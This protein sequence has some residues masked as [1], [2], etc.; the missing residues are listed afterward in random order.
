MEDEKE[1]TNVDTSKNTDD[2]DHFIAKEREEL[3]L[4]LELHKKKVIKIILACIST[5][6]ILAAIFV[7]LSAGISITNL[8]SIY[9]DTIDCTVSIILRLI[10]LYLLTII[11]IK[12]GN[13]KLYENDSKYIDIKARLMQF[14]L[15]VWKYIF[16]HSKSKIHNANNENTLNNKTNSTTKLYST[17][18]LDELINKYNRIDPVDLA[19]FWKNTIWLILFAFISIF[20]A[21]IGIKTVFFVTSNYYLHFL[22]GFTIFLCHFEMYWIQKY[23]DDCTEPDNKF[24]DANIHSHPMFVRAVPGNWCDLCWQRIDKMCYRCNNCD[25]DVCAKCWKKEKKAKKLSEKKN[26][27]KYSGDVTVYEY[28]KRLFELY[29]NHWIVLAI[30]LIIVFLTSLISVRLPASRGELFDYIFEINLDNFYEGLK[31][32]IILTVIQGLL[33]AVHNILTQRVE[34]QIMNEVQQSLYERI[35]KQ[36]MSYFDNSTA[37]VLV[38]R[39]EYGLNDA[40]SPFLSLTNSTITNTISLIGSLYFC[41]QYSFRLLLLAFSTLGPMTYLSVLFQKWHRSSMRAVWYF[42]SDLYRFASESFTN[43]RTIRSYSKEPSMKKHYNN[44]RN[45]LHNRKMK[46]ALMNALNNTIRSWF[47]LASSTLIIWAGGIL[48]FQQLQRQKNN[49][50]NIDR[51]SLQLSSSDLLTLGE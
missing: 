49:N 1:K 28:F 50:N 14:I 42:D 16:N 21:Y 45:E 32:Y 8:F 23:I 25:Y 41:W 5:E 40:L 22:F 51:S 18:N 4:K 17:F 33:N 26:K 29:V 20:Q 31:I 13:P 34:E 10:V 36:D 37:S 6:I 24:F 47:N 38:D 11:A 3:K 44:V 15:T 43:I 12:L 39:L 7:K 9:H 19:D 27:N 30:A 46:G 48:V 2:E 35:L